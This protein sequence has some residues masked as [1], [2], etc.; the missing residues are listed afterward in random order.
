MVSA[1][2]R[3]A[4]D[5]ELLPPIAPLPALEDEIET[6]EHR[7][8]QLIGSADSDQEADVLPNEAG[9]K[10]LRVSDTMR[11]RIR[12]LERKGTRAQFRHRI[13]LIG[14]AELDEKRVRA[15]QSGAGF[16]LEAVYEHGTAHWLDPVTAIAPL[17]DILFKMEAPPV[18]DR[19]VFYVLTKVARAGISPAAFATH[20]ILPRMSNDYDWRH[21]KARHI[22]ILDSIADLLSALRQ[23]P[24]W[25]KDRLGN[26]DI[27]TDIAL[28]KY[29][30]RPLARLVGERFSGQESHL[31]AWRDAW[32][33]FSFRSPA[34]LLYMRRVVL[35]CLYR[36]SGRIDPEQL[37]PI[38][39][40]L[41]GLERSF[42]RRL[43]AMKEAAVDS[44]VANAGL[45]D[46]F[47]DRVQ[48]R[49]EETQGAGSLL[50]AKEIKAYIELANELSNFDAGPALLGR[51]AAMSL[52]LD[53]SFLADALALVS[54]L[55]RRE[56]TALLRWHVEYLG[57]LLPA[58]R[59]AFI[60]EVKSSGGVY[61]ACPFRKYRLTRPE[62]CDVSE[63][64]A[65]CGFSP[66]QI[67]SM[68][69]AAGGVLGIDTLRDR[70]FLARPALADIFRTLATEVSAGYD[71]E[72][73]QD[74]LAAL[75]SDGP[76]I[77][78]LLLRSLIPGLP[79]KLAQFAGFDALFADFAR[80][81]EG[82]HVPLQLTV[83]VASGL[84]AGG[85]VEPA[86]RD[87]ARSRLAMGLF[88]KTWLS[89][90]VKEPDSECGETFAGLGKVLT[91]LQRTLD[92]E[93][94]RALNVEATAREKQANSIPLPEQ[95][96]EVIRLGAQ[97]KKLDKLFKI[98]EYIP[99]NRQDPRRFIAA[100]MFAAWFGEPGDELSMPVLQAA[101]A[102]YG[103]S[104]V[105]KELL[106]QL[107]ADISPADI[108]I[109]FLGVEQAG[110]LCDLL[111]ALCVALASDTALLECMEAIRQENGE[112]LDCLQNSSP[113]ESLPFSLVA[114]D[115]A[116]RRLCEYGR[117]C[118]ELAKWRD[119]LGKLSQD[120]S[121]KRHLHVTLSRSPL[122]VLSPFMG[123]R[124][125]AADDPAVAN[126]L[127]RPGVLTGRIADEP[128]GALLGSC[129]F[130]Y[131]QGGG[132]SGLPEKYWQ[133]FAIEPSR[134]LLRSMGSRSFLA[135]Y[136]AFRALA[137]G[138]AK[139]TGMPVVMPGNGQTLL[140]SRDPAFAAIVD[141]YER[142]TPAPPVHDT[143]GIGLYG[144]SQYGQ[145]GLLVIDPRR[146]ASFRAVRELKALGCLAAG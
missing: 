111:D 22:W 26:T 99:A 1:S 105:V 127:K 5:D 62:Q 58:K 21:W 13:A 95:D 54:A 92:S 27:I 23:Q 2:D 102:R 48:K 35:P 75:A 130:A 67:D 66:E 109:S 16:L 80:V 114:L 8:A 39:R 103:E 42:G 24:P 11:G 72:W 57:R 32:K 51:L 97:V 133:F 146:P 87:A 14:A 123:G 128:S 37:A 115:A 12:K 82:P 78:E 83:E 94:S 20:V 121:P 120:Q 122:D 7:L 65:A 88:E 28:C 139:K 84:P 17:R 85:H 134:V 124:N 64:A 86:G 63:L 101:L 129:L 77:Q 135:V 9:I 117:I 131:Q 70:L 47:D 45:L 79:R 138:L 118:L 4:S 91:S 68:R 74:R 59:S 60:E 30:G 136:L 25:E 89:L 15:Q 143:R 100:I 50:I 36:M 98:L 44:L 90:T 96:P 33:G 126:F 110:Q 106:H 41:A 142:K 29:V 132:N 40:A 93:Y 3:P 43:D 38:G 104:A 56:G 69:Q 52:K 119:L 53:G 73:N 140:L 141:S 76:A 113:A 46:G 145:T 55:Q 49:A 107:V 81:L 71:R 125:Q 108:A 19:G 137:E 31:E 144:V 112:L 6:E 18:A 61:P 116:F 34:F 10:G